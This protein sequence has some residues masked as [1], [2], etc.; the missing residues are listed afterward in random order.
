MK[1][2]AKVILFFLA[3]ILVAI[4]LFGLSISN[5][6]KEIR[7]NQDSYSLD[8]QDNPNSDSTNLDSGSSSNQDSDSSSGS[9]SSTDSSP[10]SLPDFDSADCGIYFSS[11]G[12][13]S[14]TCPSGECVSEGSSCYCKNYFW[15]ELL[16]RFISLEP[17]SKEDS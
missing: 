9:E 17:N 4:V 7:N 8:S 10:E 11:Y 14:G 6:N 1:T 12:V 5:R 13:C 2:K 15:W 3:L 16:V